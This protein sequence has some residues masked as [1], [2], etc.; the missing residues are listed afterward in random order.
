MSMPGLPKMRSR[1]YFRLIITVLALSSTLISSAQFYN[2]M[3]MSFGKNRVQHGN[4]S[5]TYFRFDDFDCYYNEFGREV[6]QFACKVAEEKLAEIEDYFDYSLDKRLILVVYNKKSDFKQSNI[7]LVSTE[8]DYNVGGYS[9][10]IKNKISLYFNG[11][12]EEFARQI[13]STIAEAVV[14][15]MVY[16]AD[17]HDKVSSS[18]EIDFPDWYIKGLSNYI[19]YGWDYESDNRARDGFVN[20]RYKNL[21]NLENE[22]AI[23]AGQSF[24]KFIGEKYGNAIIPNIIY[25][26]KVYRN[27]GDGFLYGMGQSI[28][29]TYKE[30]QTYYTDYYSAS[31]PGDTRQLPEIKKAKKDRRFTTVKVSPEGRYIAY[32]TND[33]G[34]RK[35]WIYDTQKKKNKKIFSVEPKFEQSVDF[36]YPV[37]AWHPGGRVLTFMNESKGGVRMWFYRTDDHSL[38]VR[39]MPFFEKVLNME[40]SPDGSQ[41]LL[42]AVN[43][44]MTDLYLH[45][46]ISGINERLTWDIA[47]DRDAS[48]VKEKDNTIIFSSNR[49]T[50]ILSNRGDP[51]E[52]CAETYS[53]F[54]YNIEERGSNLSKLPEKPY[55]NYRNPIEPVADATGF[56]GN[57]NGIINQYRGSIDSTI[58]LIDTTTH[59]R[60]LIDSKPITNYQRN[61]E[62]FD[63]QYKTEAAVIFDKGFYR[64]LSGPA[65][66]DIPISQKD[67]IITNF[68]KEEIERLH[69]ADSI[70]QLK[71]WLLE[72]QRKMHDTLKK[73]LYEYYA[74]DEPIDISNYIF[75][76]EKENYYELQWRKAYLD[77]DLDTSRMQFPTARVYRTVFYNNYAASQIDFNFLNYS[78]QA[79][80]GGSAYYNPGVNL[81][82]KIGAIDLFEDYRITGGFRFSGNFDSNEYLLSLEALKG[83]FDKQFIYHQQ[84]FDTYD[85]EGYYKIKSY[86]TYF[87]LSKPFSNVLSFKGTLIYRFDNYITQSI[88]PGSLTAENLHRHWGGLKGEIIYDN[89]RKRMINIYYG[90]RFKIFGE[91]YHEF[92]TRNKN[93]YVIGADFRHYTKIHRE[94]IWANRFAA[95]GS[96][97][98]TKLIYFLGGVDN[99]MGYFFNTPMFDSSVPV[100]PNAS[101]G[102]QA[103]ATNM[104]GFSQ[105]IRN[106]S[107]FA[108]FNSEIRWPIVRYF[109]GHPL[110]SSFLNSIQVVGFADAGMA[111]TGWNPWSNENYWDTST[112]ENG[113]IIVHLDTDRDPIVLGTG[114]GA[115]AQILGYFVKADWAWGIEN[116]YV[117]PKI[118]YLSFSLDF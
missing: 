39:D 106:G 65:T 81:F 110:R 11:D 33:W 84:S 48:F 31:Q 100:N 96:F 43:A 118:F 78:Y 63:K 112:Y 42:T 66:S 92:L 15:E 37:M 86:N 98:S 73:P 32:V 94:L 17:T 87:S 74:K 27:V 82:F 72:E 88:D 85:E 113:S 36:T 67:I 44:G 8:D 51:L 71:Q 5:W 40:Y 114:F 77:I 56:L 23:V 89:T 28:K 79:Y 61:I 52:D 22:D 46:I 21:D 58:S 34:K 35:I 105:N 26:S 14:Y 101:Y 83:K 24:W 20:K 55:D 117:L 9:R 93:L 12:H 64:L 54:T 60:Y 97:G 47:D 13:A 99:W 2:G 90:T 38:E 41:L 69:S 7:G 29:D 80:N 102:F 108:L 6:A 49:K 107:N 4:F 1:G 19:A 45:T 109:V 68:K 50:D 57:G 30:W 16:N 91:Y 18:A 116:G 115:R 103:L 25:L 59:Y 70:A 76:K 10:I 95:S 75:E 111:W 53:L 62:A 3:Q 104:R